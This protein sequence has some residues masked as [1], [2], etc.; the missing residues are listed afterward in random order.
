MTAAIVDASSEG[1][2]LTDISDLYI[3]NTP[4]ILIVKIIF[5]VTL[6]TTEWA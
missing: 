6:T 1:L 4:S 5:I 3:I 2:N